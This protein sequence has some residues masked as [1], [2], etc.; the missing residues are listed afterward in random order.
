MNEP[1]NYLALADEY[2]SWS[3]AQEEDDWYRKYMQLD[4]ECEEE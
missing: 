1:T 3:E 2:E 4:E